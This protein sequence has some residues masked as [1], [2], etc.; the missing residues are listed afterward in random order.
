MVILALQGVKNYKLA[1]SRRTVH[2]ACLLALFGSNL[3]SYGIRPRNDINGPPS[4][5][6]HKAHM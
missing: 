5:P 1:W 4:V 2:L 6:A 3:E